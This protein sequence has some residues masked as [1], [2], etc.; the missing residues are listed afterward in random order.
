MDN[1][2][3]PT[4]RLPQP[5]RRT[6]YSYPRD[7]RLPPNFYQTDPIDR[8]SPYYYPPGSNQSYFSNS[9]TSPTGQTRA[10]S[11]DRASLLPRVR[12]IPIKITTDSSRLAQKPTHPSNGIYD[13]EVDPAM[14]PQ[15]S[16]S[17]SAGY[18]PRRTPPREFGSSR[19]P[20]SRYHFGNQSLTDRERQV[21]QTQP[22]NHL[23]R[24]SAESH[25]ESPR[26]NTYP[27]RYQTPMSYNLRHAPPA[28]QRDVWP[29][30]ARYYPSPV[31]NPN[32]SRATPPKNSPPSPSTAPFNDSRRYDGG[33]TQIR[34]HNEHASEGSTQ[35]DG[36]TENQLEPTYTAPNHPPESSQEAATSFP[37]NSNPSDESKKNVVVISE[38]DILYSSTSSD[39]DEVVRGC[40]TEGQSHETELNLISKYFV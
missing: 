24:G 10:F 11:S 6:D 39:E 5:F 26:Q 4:T 40:Y 15:S 38:T 12:H 19:I 9:A 34:L 16:T 27:S 28:N 18:L 3:I 33:L 36:A 23:R 20:M 1:G 21:I 25:L 30:V 8:H 32:V 2:G 17:T 22:V 14:Y 13:A 7:T 29:V 35:R 31:T 37:A